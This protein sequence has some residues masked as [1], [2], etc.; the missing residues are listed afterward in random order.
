MS[1]DQ[2]HEIG[3]V[4]S[5]PK[6]G[7]HRINSR[8]LLEARSRRGLRYVFDRFLVRTLVFGFL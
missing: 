3:G 8:G 4:E 6:R 2:R 7:M 1:K 5:A